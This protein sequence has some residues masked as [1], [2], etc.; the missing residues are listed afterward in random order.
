MHTLLALLAGMAA[1]QSVQ[2]YSE[3]RRIDPKGQMLALD[4]MDKPR[5]ILSPAFA[6]NAFHSLRVAIHVSAGKVYQLNLA[7]NPED[8]VE[9]KLYRELPAA[10]GSPIRD[11]LVP[12]K[13]PVTGK[14][15]VH[16]SF[17]LDLWATALAPVRRVRVEVQLH[18]GEGWFIYPMEAR[19]LSAIVPQHKPANVALPSYKEPAAAAARQALREFVCN[20][21]PPSGPAGLT[22][23]H[24]LRRNALQDLALARALQVTWGREKLIAA[25]VQAAGGSDPAAWCNEKTQP[26]TAGSEWYLKV[27][28]FLYREASH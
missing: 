17:W 26:S 22:I 20:E 27:R 14:G 11:R 3:F 21:T 23:R 25:L 7:Q 18:D 15:P 9:M 5:E 12:V 6:R 28:D 4:D 24:L 1:A 16:D 8:A 2:V 10:Q 19:I 13:L